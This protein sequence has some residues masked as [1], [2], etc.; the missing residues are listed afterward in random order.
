MNKAISAPTS[1]CTHYLLWRGD[2]EFEPQ[3]SVLFDRSI[4]D[5]LAADAIWGLVNLV[6][7]FL[8]TGDKR[9]LPSEEIE[10]IEI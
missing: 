2:E 9:F 1:S 10:I 6:S 7:D 8:L 5:P 3:L 4:E